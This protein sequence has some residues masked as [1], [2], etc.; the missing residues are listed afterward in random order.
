MRPDA[1]RL[2]A[3]R[4]TAACLRA[5][6]GWWRRRRCM[7][8]SRCGN[9]IL[10]CADFLVGV[11]DPLQR[12]RSRDASPVHAR[13][14]EPHAKTFEFRPLEGERL[15]RGSRLDTPRRHGY[16]AFALGK[17]RR[18][19]RNGPHQSDERDQCAHGKRIAWTLAVE[20][21]N[22]EEVKQDRSANQYVRDDPIQAAGVS[23]LP[24]ERV[25]VILE[26][27]IAAHRVEDRCDKL[28]P[29]FRACCGSGGRHSANS[30]G[31]G[32]GRP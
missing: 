21:E 2:R 30:S 9:G 26:A 7:A 15:V 20:Q 8:L 17:E 10:E 16:V 12:A 11:E 13:H 27:A 28:A 14:A 1:A 3:S 23:G 31:I 4:C 6:L 22:L 5:R 32:V 18:Q 19:P 29:A 25:L 24:D